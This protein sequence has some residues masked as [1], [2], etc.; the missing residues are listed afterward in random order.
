MSTRLPDPAVGSGDRNG[1]PGRALRG[2]A[3]RGSAAP[4]DTAQAL[5]T[6]APRN[7]AA[8]LESASPQYSSAPLTIAAPHNSSAPPAGPAGVLR[9]ARF[10]AAT[11][12]EGPG[13]RAALWLQGCSIHCPGCFNPHLWSARGGK[14]ADTSQKA[15]LFVEQAVRAG[16]EGLTL[17]GGEPFEQAAAAAVVASAFRRAGLGV[18]TFTGYTYPDLQRWAQER[19]DISALLEATDLLADG[20]YLAGR[21]ERIRP[22]IGSTNQGLRA[23]TDRYRGRIP[24][25]DGNPSSSPASSPD[26]GDRLEVRVAPDGTVAVNGWAETAALEYLLYG[27]NRPVPA[28]SPS[29]T[30]PSGAASKEA[31]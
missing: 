3:A 23:L 15:Q 14:E 27:L 2:D 19:P 25:A 12:A 26:G 28:R 17:L 21:P 22:W 18:M 31:P 6:S 24:G 9:Y 7:A 4:L 20:P 16:A 8:L 29:P 5:K 11:E 10:L 1:A 30:V 13:K